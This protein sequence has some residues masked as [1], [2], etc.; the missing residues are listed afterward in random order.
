MPIP[1][2]PGEVPPEEGAA[3]P[4]IDI[5]PS[6]PKV[7]Q[8]KIFGLIFLFLTALYGIYFNLI[9]NFGSASILNLAL[10]GAFTGA[11]IL[12]G[13]IAFFNEDW[14][15]WMG[16]FSTMALV[17]AVAARPIVTSITTTGLQEVFIAA[18]WAF[19]LFMF[20]ELLDAYQRF[21]DIA[22]MA[23]ERGLPTVNID[24]VISNFR[25]RSFAFAGLFLF[26][27][28]LLLSLGTVALGALIGIGTSLENYEVF[29]Q[30][31]AIVVVFTLWA[32]ANVFLFM[33]LEK[34]TEVEQ[35]A[36]SRE[37][38]RAMVSHGAAP[39]PPAGPTGPAAPRAPPPP[40]MAPGPRGPASGPRGPAPGFAQQR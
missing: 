35:V 5:E 23:V 12:F 31:M 22:R 27:T 1:P 38:I 40:P 14:R 21:T 33:Y 9:V 11:G 10:C 26:I 6:F 30:A 18:I 25:S 3:V 2:L 7:K 36:Y 17:G 32:V 13:L 24:Q 29:G 4:R 39:P 28:G 19:A 16:Y 37:Q 8:I 34:K 15:R 20:Y